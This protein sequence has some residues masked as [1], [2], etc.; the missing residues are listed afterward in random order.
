[1]S[2]QQRIFSYYS[3]LKF[4]NSQIDIM[5]EIYTGTKFGTR[6]Q[7]D[8]LPQH[9]ALAELKNYCAEFAEKG[10]APPYEGGSSGNLSFR[11]EAGS[12]AFYVTASY[13]AL[14]KNMSDSDFCLVHEVDFQSGTVIFS[15][16]RNPSSEAM[17]HDAIYKA[18]PEIMAVFHGHSEDIME[19]AR[20]LQMPV[21]QHEMPY[22]TLE[23]VT[24]MLK[25][26][27]QHTLFILKNHGFVSLGATM[28]Y[29]AE[30]ADF[31]ADIANVL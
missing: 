11:A 31:Y 27:D 7:S 5:A 10:Y 1:M 29:A 9:A 6:K 19:A 16:T 13:T 4:P 30:E 20:K 15:G 24:E 14:G 12:N 2:L 26:L 3:I 8:S 17:M 18:R 23:V 25:I 21:T 28:E 22:G